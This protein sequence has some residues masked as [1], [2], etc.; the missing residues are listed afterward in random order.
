VGST[1]THGGE[2]DAKMTSVDELARSYWEAE[3][4]RDIAAIVEHFAA[5]AVWRG[6]GAL[7]LHGREEIG[8]FYEEAARAFPGLELEVI[9]VFGDERSAALQWR[10]VLVDPDG[11]RHR[12]DGVNVMTGDGVHITSLHTYFDRLQVSLGSKEKE[13]ES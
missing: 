7:E 12:F 1:E 3:Q 6:P 5:D 9:G 2:T 4:R 13:E 11:G 8:G 10:G